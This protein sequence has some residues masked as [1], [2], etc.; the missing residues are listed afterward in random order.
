MSSVTTQFKKGH[1][2]LKGKDNGM[3]KH[4]F[5]KTKQYHAKMNSALYHKKLLEKAGRPKPDNCETCQTPAD[6]LK[7]GLYFDHDH[8]TGKFRGWICHPCNSALGMMKDNI[9]I[10]ETMV[11]YL[12][13]SPT[14]NPPL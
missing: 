14:E 12:K 2:G 13:A 6:Q 5:T 9:Q 8:A 7:R 4:G 11:K 3:F 1:P 10:A